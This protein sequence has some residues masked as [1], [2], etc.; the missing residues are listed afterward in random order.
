VTALSKI[1]GVLKA[2][3][4]KSL[5][6]DEDVIIFK[7]REEERKERGEGGTNK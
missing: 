7:G 4:S 6:Q 3:D 5:N 1:G 2:G